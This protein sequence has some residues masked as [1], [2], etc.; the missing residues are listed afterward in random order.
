MATPRHLRNAPISE[1]IVDFRVQAREGITTEQ[2]SKA[3]STLADRF[4]E[5]IEVWSGRANIQWPAGVRASP[6]MTHEGAATGFHFKSADGLDIAQF[7]VD[8]FTYNRLGPYTSW[9]TIYP[10]VME[11]WATYVETAQPHMISRLAVRYL[12]RIDLSEYFDIPVN[13]DEF[14]SALTALPRIPDGLPNTVSRFLTR[15]TIH[16]K[17][18]GIAAH[19]SQAVDLDKT[20]R[21]PVVLLDIDAFNPSHIEPA[22]DQIAGTL[23]SLRE[24]KNRVFFGSLTENAVRRFE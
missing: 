4:P 15:V 13:L 6:T 11:L 24:L 12:N 5:Q 18:Q 21:Q 14:S 17:Q 2:L 16:D 10:L 23:E 22:S 7:R 1:A 9:E 20:S 19:V 3:H 8:G